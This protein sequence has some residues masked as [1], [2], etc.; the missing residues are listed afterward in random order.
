MCIPTPKAPAPQV[1]TQAAPT[2]SMTP[3]FES[4]LAEIDTQSTQKMKKRKGKD[5][6]KI[7]SADPAISVNTTTGSSGS[8]V[9]IT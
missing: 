3:D 7:A 9:N 6:L 2:T 5:K 1:Q 8:G 4:G